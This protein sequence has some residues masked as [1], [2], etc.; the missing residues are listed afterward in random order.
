MSLNLVHPTTAP[1]TA[2]ATTTTIT[3]SNRENDHY[4]YRQEGST[5]QMKEE[6][7]RKEL[8]VTSRIWP[9]IPE[10]DDIEIGLEARRDGEGG[11]L[12]TG[13]T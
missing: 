2:A 10:M 5:K 6:R 7:F 3:K 9:W 13:E 4:I 12:L 11:S 8:P 1:P